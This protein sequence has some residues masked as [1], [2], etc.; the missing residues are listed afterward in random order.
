MTPI[1]RALPG[2]ALLVLLSMPRVALPD[3]ALPTGRLDRP[4]DGCPE[5]SEITLTDLE[6]ESYGCD[7]TGVGGL[8]DQDATSC[9]YALDTDCSSGSG[10]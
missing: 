5:P 4:A 8:F 9:W 2:A 6:V 1:R 3:V 10:C 7:V